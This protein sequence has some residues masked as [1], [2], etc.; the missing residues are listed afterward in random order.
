M[1]IQVTLNGLGR[2]PLY[3]CMCDNNKEKGHGIQRNKE[4]NMGLEEE[5]KKENMVELYFSFEIKM[6]GSGG[7]HL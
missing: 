1:Y 5:R 2:S 7:A 3:I 4:E 6:Q